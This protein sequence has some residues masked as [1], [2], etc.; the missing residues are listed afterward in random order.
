MPLVERGQDVSEY[1]AV[2][3]TAGAHGDPLSSMEHARGGDDL[4]HFVLEGRVE[5][6][7]ANLRP[8]D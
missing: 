8:V 5:A 4:V 3:S 2:L 7:P 1:S 6:F